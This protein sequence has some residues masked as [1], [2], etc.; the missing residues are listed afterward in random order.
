MMET[1]EAGERDDR[2]KRA[3]EGVA[4]VECAVLHTFRFGGRNGMIMMVRRPG[5]AANRGRSPGRVAASGDR[6]I[7]VAV[8]CGGSDSCG[9]LALATSGLITKGPRIVAGLGSRPSDQRHASFSGGHGL[10]ET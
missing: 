9:A 5:A 7:T 3:K 2:H 8:I 4:R 1:D 6:G 10:C